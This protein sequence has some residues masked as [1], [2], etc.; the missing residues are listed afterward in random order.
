MIYEPCWPCKK[1]AYATSSREPQAERRF[2]IWLVID[3]RQL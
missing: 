3:V 2:D 1:L